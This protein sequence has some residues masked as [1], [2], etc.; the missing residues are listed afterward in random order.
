MQMAFYNSEQFPEEYR[1]DAF[2]A[3]HG[4]WNRDPVSGYEIARIQFDDGKPVRF[5]PFVTGFVSEDAATTFGRPAGM[6][7]AKDGSLLIGDDGTGVIY[8][9]TYTPEK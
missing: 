6:A 2:V 8:R 1:G 9:V 3:M 4:S 5:H 7:I